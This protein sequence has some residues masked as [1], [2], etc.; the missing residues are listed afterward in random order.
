MDDARARPPLDDATVPGHRPRLTGSDPA[1]LATRRRVWLLVALSLLMIAV[2]A[3]VPPLA[4]DPA[5]HAFADART[6]LHMPNFLNVTSNL[7][8]VLVGALGLAYL[9]RDRRTGGHAAFVTPGAR[10]PYWL[11]FTGIT[12]TGVGSAYYHWRP[13]NATLFWD[14]LPMTIAF[15]AL[16]A[17]VIGERIGRRAGAR[18]LW[19]LLIAGAASTLYWHLGEQRGAGDLRPYGVVQFG[20]MV[21]VPLILVLFPARYTGTRYL[22]MSIGW[23]GLAKV[24]EYFDH[25]LFM[26]AGVS[27][28]TWKHLASAVGAYWILRMLERRRPLTPG[29]PLGCAPTIGPD[30]RR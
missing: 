20:S 29:G 10:Q 28:H 18:C 17:S 2:A 23:Y 7:P 4:Q 6:V 5:Y 14:R 15:M 27:G 3:S 25:G 8:F 12:L 30:A 13:D 26:R 19:P 21:L 1:A 9:T 24:F 22:W 11:F 16:L